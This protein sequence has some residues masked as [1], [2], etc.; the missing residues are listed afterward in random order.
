MAFTAYVV[1]ANDRWVTWLFDLEE[2]I[3]IT[4][5]LSMVAII[6]LNSTVSYLFE[7]IIIWYLT[8]W[9]KKRLER[10]KQIQ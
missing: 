2:D 7:K 8:L 10:K 5:R 9:W 3:S 4:F 6:F 1:I